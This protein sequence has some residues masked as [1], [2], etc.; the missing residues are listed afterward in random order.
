MRFSLFKSVGLS[1]LLAAPVTSA[2][3]QQVPKPAAD[4]L[5]KYERPATGLGAVEKKSFFQS[6]GF[7]ASIIPAVLIGYGVSTINGHGFYSS[8]QAHDDIR[9]VFGDYRN[10]ADNYLQFAPYLELG[11]VLL[12]GVKSRNDRVNLGL[13]ILKSELIMVTSVYIVKFATNIDRPDGTPTAFPSGHTAQAFLAAS[14]LHTE[15]RDKSQWYGIGAYTI[16]TGVAALRMINDKH[17]ES[18]VVAGAGFGIFSAHL[19]YLT[20]RYRWG[21]KPNETATLHV[22]PLYYAGAT[23]LSLNWQLH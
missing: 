6:K 23:G 15:L 21:H 17:W 8:Y 13:V 5:H 3:A 18:D 11:G 16:A 22:S 1:W 12:A 2:L 20:H 9:R 7:R 4:T 14:I 10:H 19:G